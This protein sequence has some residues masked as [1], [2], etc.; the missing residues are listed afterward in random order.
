VTLSFHH[1]G[2]A[3][4]DLAPETEAFGML[5]YRVEGEDFV[6][7][8]Q[9]IRGRFLVGP[10]PRLELLVGL[11][12]SSVLD[13]WLDKGVKFYHQAFLVE[14]LETSVGELRDQGGRIVLPSMPAVAFGGRQIAFVMLRNLA[15][16]ELI[17]SDERRDA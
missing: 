16:V 11:P 15:L 14:S 2:V 7:P 3:C 4:R 5:G 1:I 13:L 10:G 12:G 17:E 9:G 6:D 8:G